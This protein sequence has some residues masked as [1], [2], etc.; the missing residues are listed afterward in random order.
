MPRGSRDLAL[1]LVLRWNLY[2]EGIG[3]DR[4]ERPPRHEVEAAKVW[5]RFHARPAHVFNTSRDSYALKHLAE[6]GSDEHGL[7]EAYFS[8]GAF[9]RAALELGYGARRAP[10]ANAYFKMEGEASGRRGNDQ[11]EGL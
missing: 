7:T 11:P 10:G 9:I 1:T 8:N 4:G 2:L 5:P 6:R 3:A